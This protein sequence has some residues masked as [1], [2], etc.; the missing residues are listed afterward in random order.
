MSDT[1]KLGVLLL[2]GLDGTGELLKDLRNRLS[3]QRPVQV[4]SY[5]ADKPLGYDQLTTLVLDRVPKERF[6][7]LGE[8][9]SGPIAI[10][11][12]ALE[13]QRV[14]GLILASS[15]ARHPMP[16]LLAAAAPML[17]LKWIPRSIVE[18]VLMGSAGDLELKIALARELSR[19]PRSVIRARAAE[20]LRIDKRHRLREVVCPILCLHGRLDRLVRE[21]STNEIRSE[22]PDCQIHWFDAPHML[23]ETHAAEAASAINQFCE[24]LN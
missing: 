10:E 16:T 8:S 3:A 5:P 12:A 21:K 4:I 7:I 24:R 6:V 17:D 23:L 20:A 2:P 15:F 9:F 13:K 19:M 18:A 22:Q 14:A 11:V 1:Q